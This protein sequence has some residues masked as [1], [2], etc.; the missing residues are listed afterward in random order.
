MHTSIF[1][2]PFL[3]SVLALIVAPLAILPISA[4][5]AVDVNADCAAIYGD[6]FTP[7]TGQ[8]ISPSP[9]SPRPAKGVPFKDPAFGTCVVRATDHATEAPSGFARND[10]SRRQAFNVDNTR[11]LVYALNGAWHL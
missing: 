5:R 9:T 4:A 7:V 10:Y 2:R 11:V 3:K 1:F 8:V 6:A